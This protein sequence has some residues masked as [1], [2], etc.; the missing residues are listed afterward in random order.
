MN[1]SKLLI[2]LVLQKTRINKQGKCPIRCRLT[3]QKKRKEFATGQFVNPDLWNSKKQ[4]V[5]PPDEQSEY[6]NSQLSLITQK[7]NQAFLFLQVNGGDFDV[8]DIYLQYKGENITKNKTLLE[9]F[10]LHNSK[11]E[12]L[13]G[14]GYSKATF[15]KFK[16]AQNHLSDFLKHTYKRNDI[17]LAKLKIKFL[18]DLEHY[19]KSEK[20][21]K[22]ITINKTIQRIR[23]VVKLGLAEGYMDSDPFI[24]YK[25]KRYK[26]EVV[27]LT[28]DELSKLK[29][30]DF[31][32]NARLERIRDCFLFCCYTGLA[33]AEMSNLKKEHLVNAFDGNIWIQMDRKK[34]GTAVNIPLLPIAQK[35][36]DKYRDENGL[37]PIV[38]NQKFNSYLKEIGVILGFEKKLTHHI[39]RK[40]FATTVLL[41]NDVPMEIVSELLGHSKMQITQ[42]HYGKVVQKKIS[43]VM[44]D[45]CVKLNQKK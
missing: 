18:D 7:L 32:Y 37:L 1:N 15:Y 5:K 9:T 6:I 34:T 39:A 27:Y 43:D 36:L 23:K 29:E 16:E 26:V 35:I 30:H 17:P 21:Q 42:R 2:L 19:L 8:N 24:L 44:N 38:S 40:T 3:Y 25:P 4:I 11:M 22:Q 33:Y 45:L 41:Y 14:R 12:K 28:S 31:S 20:N 10:R 13:L